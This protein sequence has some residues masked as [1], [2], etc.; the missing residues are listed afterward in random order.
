VS[1]LYPALDVIWPLRPDD[2]RVDVLLAEVDDEG[3]LAVQE[4]ES[5]LRVFF[6]TSAARGRAAVKLIA[7][8]PDL[9]CTP[10]E[11]P[12]EDWAAR[13]QAS[14]GPVTVGRIVV[15]P[16][17]LHSIIIQPSMGFGTGHHASTRLCL[18]L[19]QNV[20]LAGRSVIDVGTGSGVLA[21]AA[22]KLGA[23]SVLAIDNDEDAL[24]SA[25]ENVAL[26]RADVEL[27]LSDLEVVR[28]KNAFDVIL[29]NLTGALLVRQ[30]PALRSLLSGDGVLIVSG[31]T[32]AEGADVKAAF[33]SVGFAV[34][35]EV[36]EDGWIGLSLTIP[37]PSTTR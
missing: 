25:R 9:T 26:N 11:I 12:D 15:V 16:P 17:W 8:E 7:L 29:A 20:P 2:E 4:I 23:A 33:V 22:S 13:S 34:A 1:R 6:P 18:Q 37:T 19:L 30:A 21:I 31:V 5:G 10:Q 3:P 27:Q 36:D 32:A 28:G 14:I 24:T 35:Q